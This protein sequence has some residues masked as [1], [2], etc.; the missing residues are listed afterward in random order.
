[1][2][3]TARANGALLIC[4][5][6]R[7]PWWVCLPGLPP[8]AGRCV[9]HAHNKEWVQPLL[10]AGR[11]GIGRRGPLEAQFHNLRMVGGVILEAPWKRRHGQFFVPRLGLA[12]Q[13]PCPTPALLQPLPEMEY[14]GNPASVGYKIKYSRADGHGKVLSHV[15]LDRVEREYTIEDLEEWTEYR[16]QVQAFNAIGSGPWSPMVM[17][18]TR[19]SGTA[20][21]SQPPPWLPGVWCWD[22]PTFVSL[23]SG[24]PKGT[25]LEPLFC[26]CSRPT[27]HAVP[28][29]P[30][31]PPS[32]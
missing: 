16:V 7:Q 13:L 31:S 8:L 10:G 29:V 30:P 2:A 23:P 27:A 26:L 25:H 17:G 15:V 21:S 1:M 19:E 24:P 6:G 4:V 18:R 9:C 14:N 12:S 5:L 3:E 28:T 32:P 11:G 22:A 20:P